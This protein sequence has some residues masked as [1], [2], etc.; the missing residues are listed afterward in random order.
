MDLPGFTLHYRFLRIPLVLLAT[1]ELNH[2]LDLG[3]DVGGNFIL[4]E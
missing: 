3:P 2:R 1:A 4:S